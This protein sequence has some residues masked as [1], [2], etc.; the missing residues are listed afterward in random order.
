MSITATFNE[1]VLLPCTL[2]RQN[3]TTNRP[4][5]CAR[6][7][8]TSDFHLKTQGQSRATTSKSQP[9][10]DCINYGV[11]WMHTVS[12]FNLITSAIFSPAPHFFPQ[13]AVAYDGNCQT[14]PPASPTL[15]AREVH[16]ITW[17]YVTIEMSSNHK[18]THLPGVV[19]TWR[20]GR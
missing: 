20:G 13:N 10:A 15:Q 4:K 12:A 19:S 5:K 7:S 6:I 16:L 17:D 9:A 14:T 3:L 2:S 18:G 11:F 1:K 8:H